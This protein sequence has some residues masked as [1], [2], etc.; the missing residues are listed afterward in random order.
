LYKRYDIAMMSLISYEFYILINYIF[1]LKLI[2]KIDDKKY[3]ISLGGFCG[4]SVA[5][6][7][8]NLGPLKSV[9]SQ[10]KEKYKT[11]R[12]PNNNS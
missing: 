10:D 2:N 12:K 5:T 3:R 4:Y 8:S 1:T 9:F 6:L 11:E 7:L